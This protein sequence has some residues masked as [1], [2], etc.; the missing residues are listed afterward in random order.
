MGHAQNALKIIRG[1]RAKIANAREGVGPQTKTPRH[2]M[3]RKR[4][5]P[6]LHYRCNPRREDGHPRSIIR[7]YSSIMTLTMAMTGRMSIAIW[8]TQQAYGWMVSTTIS[9]HRGPTLPG[10]LNSPTEQSKEGQLLTS[11]STG[12]V[13]NSKS[14]SLRGKI[15]KKMKN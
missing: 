3:Q 13:P 6:I 12:S 4:S 15:L 1:P 9:P 11:K 10:P 2:P 14:Q 7:S 5:L 8:T